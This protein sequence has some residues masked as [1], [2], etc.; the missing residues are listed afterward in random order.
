MTIKDLAAQ[1][2]YSVG[3]ISRVLNNQPNVSEKARKAI[4]EAAAACGFQLN[5]NAQQL[6]QQRS[7]NILVLVKGSSNQLFGAL[8]EAIQRRVAGSPFHLVVDYMDE[9]H[10]EVLRAVQLCREKKPQGLI[11]LGGNRKN[12]LAD[13]RRIDV[14][15]VLITSDASDLPFHNLCSVCCDEDQAVK[16][17]IE[18]L[19]R[20][21]HRQIGIIGGYRERSDTSRRRFEGCR[22]AF[23]EHNIPF[24]AE[25]DYASSRFSYADSYRAAK[26]LASRGRTYTA[27]FCM[28][29][30]MAMGAMRALA[31]SGLRV[32]EDV[33]V[34][35][36]DGLAIGEFIVPRLS[37][38]SQ[39]VELLAQRG[40]ELLRGNIEGKNICVHEIIPA[41][42]QWK[43]S[44]K[45]I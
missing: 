23:I 22:Q 35:G 33:S 2:G 24:D 39:N 37:T 8:V 42:I 3:T 38:V 5:T 43:E 20:M 21:G 1:T 9:D 18:Q 6:K 10:N 17:T 34:V 11:F 32:P 40:I 19:I 36:F 4:L 30:V 29:D 12:F 7:N 27:V 44:A 16:Q 28:A 25:L 45:T 26:E 31:D 15:C 13:F 41:Q 14:P